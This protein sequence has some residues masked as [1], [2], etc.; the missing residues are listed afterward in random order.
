MAVCTALYLAPF[1]GDDALYI[2]FGLMGAAYLS[3]AV[4]FYKFGF[5][6]GERSATPPSPRKRRP[7]LRLIS[8]YK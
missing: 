6:D 1:R 3:F 4:F 8:S 7:E 2:A 5:S